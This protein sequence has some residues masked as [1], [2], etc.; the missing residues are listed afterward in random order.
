MI[1]STATILI[2]KGF[3]PQEIV[4]QFESTRALFSVH[5]RR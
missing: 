5:G 2:R 1:Y 3:A 4:I